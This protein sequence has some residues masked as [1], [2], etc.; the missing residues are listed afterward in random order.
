M[1]LHDCMYEILRCKQ[2]LYQAIANGQPDNFTM[3]HA[4][5]IESCHANFKSLSLFISLEIDCSH[6]L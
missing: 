2:Y 5:V 4:R 1:L 6:G 3:S